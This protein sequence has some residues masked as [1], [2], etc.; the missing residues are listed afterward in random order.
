MAGTGTD[1]AALGADV[2]FVYVTFPEP[3]PA[4][5]L[6]R[7]AVEAGLAAC[8]N[9]VGGMRSVY[10]WQ[11]AIEEAEETIA[12]FKTSALR[13]EALAAFVTEHHPYDEPAI[14]VLPIAGGSPS[15]LDWIRRE[16]G[17]R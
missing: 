14:A 4:H 7:A 10:R 13:A 12:I 8:V 1:E 3:G 15:Y 5:D 16:S 2:V 6:A 17:S 11:G 9:I